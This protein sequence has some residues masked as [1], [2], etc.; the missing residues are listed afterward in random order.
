MLPAKKRRQRLWRCSTYMPILPRSI[1]PCRSLKAWNRPV[2]VLPALWRLIR[3]RHLC[4]MGRLCNREPLISSDKISRKHLT[5]S[6]SIKTI[7]S[8]MYGRPHGVY[9]HD[10]WGLL[11]CRTPMIT[12]WYCR[13]ISHL[14][15]SLSYLFTKM[16]SNWLKSMPKWPVSPKLYAVWVSR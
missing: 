8:N 5:C 12:D 6:L 11:S 2:N 7:N 9:R 1:W 4:K 13:L 3:S 14:Y 15:R 10:W 16:P